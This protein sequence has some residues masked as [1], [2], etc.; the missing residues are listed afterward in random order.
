[1]KPELTAVMVTFLQ[2]IASTFSRGF[3]PGVQGA[4]DVEICI[5]LEYK[6][7]VNDIF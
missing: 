1:M 7:P 2:N 4:D 3:A 6:I 5:Y